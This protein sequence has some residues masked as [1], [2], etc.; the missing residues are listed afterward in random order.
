LVFGGSL[1]REGEDA[2]PRHPLGDGGAVVIGPVDGPE[3]RRGGQSPLVSLTLPS[4][5]RL[6]TVAALEREG[7]MPR[8]L[9]GQAIESLRGESLPEDHRM[10]RCHVYLNDPLH[11]F[12]RALEAEGERVALEL[13]RDGFSIRLEVHH[14]KGSEASQ[15]RQ[16]EADAR[17][18]GPGDLFVVIPINQDG[19]YR[20]VGEILTQCADAVCVF[21]QQSLPRLLQGQRAKNP[22]RLFSVAA[23]QLEIGRIQARQLAAL[24]PGRKGS[25]LYVQGRENSY[26]TRHRTKGLLEELARTPEVRLQ[27]FRVHGDWTPESVRPA[28]EAWRRLGSRLEQ[29]QAAAAQNDEMAIA[30][31]EIVRENRLTIPVTGVDGLSNGKK[32][33][34]QGRLAATVV[35]PLGISHALRVYRDLCEGK[36]EASLIPAD[37]N[38][39]EAPKSYPELIRLRR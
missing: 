26:G 36:P 39:L 16:M 29:I 7:L 13:G 30:L 15:L 34:E 11:P 38:I 17:S 31:A 3:D 32:A 12:D 5:E 4:V 24:V 9:W 33:V 20:I 18:A 8:G 21:L 10:K 22:R 37:G 19:A 23:D 6:E 25:I 27:G 35:Q 14:A 1:D 28:V 2:N